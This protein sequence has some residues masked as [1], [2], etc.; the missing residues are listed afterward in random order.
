MLADMHIGEARLLR[1]AG[2]YLFE[3]AGCQATSLDEP[4]EL[5]RAFTDRVDRFRS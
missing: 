2:A 1:E 5:L 4:Q 3:V